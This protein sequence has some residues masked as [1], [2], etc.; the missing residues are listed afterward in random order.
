MWYVEFSFGKFRMYFFVLFV[1]FMV[2]NLKLLFLL[3]VFGGR[4]FSSWCLSMGI[5]FS[6]DGKRIILKV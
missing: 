2:S 4:N 3:C 5:F 1:S 6:R